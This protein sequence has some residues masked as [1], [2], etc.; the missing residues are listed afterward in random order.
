MKGGKAV[1][2]LTS[3]VLISGV[4]SGALSGCNKSGEVPEL[5]KPITI[6]ESYVSVKYGDVGKTVNTV[7]TVVP[8]YRSVYPHSVVAVEKLY[9]KVGDEVKEGDVLATGVSMAD[10]N[11]MDLLNSEINYL[12]SDIG[13]E[14]RIGSIES[15]IFDL[16]MKFNSLT[17]QGDQND[18]LKTA[19]R[20]SQLNTDYSVTGMRKRVKSLEKQ[21]KELREDIDK[22]EIKAPVSG[23]IVYARNIANATDY[24]TT[25]DNALFIIEDESEKFIE[26]YNVNQSQFSMDDRSVYYL[27]NGEKTKLTPVEYTTEENSR[28]RIKD[29]Y[30]V[31]LYKC[32]V[33]GVEIGDQIPVTIEADTKKTNVLTVDNNAVN[34]EGNDAYVYVKTDSGTEKRFITIGSV[35]DLDSEVK[36]GLTEN[37]KVLVYF[38][39]SAPQSYKEIK[40]DYDDFKA[41]RYSEKLYRAIDRSTAVAADNAMKVKDTASHSGNLSAGTELVVADYSPKQSALL[42]AKNQLERNRR[43]HSNSISGFNKS[44]A[45]LEKATYPAEMSPDAVKIMKQINAL[46]ISQLKLQRQSENASFALSEKEYSETYNK[47][48]KLSKEKEVSIKLE[49]DA[50]VELHVRKDDSVDKGAVIYS[51]TDYTEDSIAICGYDDIVAVPIYK[52]ASLEPK[53]GKDLPVLEGKIVGYGGGSGHCYVTTEDENVYVTTA[54]PAYGSDTQR[55]MVDFGKNCIS[56]SVL[57]DYKGKYTEVDVNGIVSLPIECIFWEEVTNIDNQSGYKPY[58][59]KK[60]DEGIVQSYVELFKSP[61]LTEKIWVIK[62]V[63]PGE[64]ILQPTGAEAQHTNHQEDYFGKKK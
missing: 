54:A 25:S 12:N 48:K 27:H 58:V 32:D 50:K 14:R 24:M 5:V 23:K 15:E 37:D 34:Y 41:Y 19:K 21:K 28:M 10:D 49:E 3:V 31:L 6:P 59:W 44:I 62:G 43:S 61:V 60:T 52:E 51:S 7:G 35:D 56:D 55:I 2:K 22:L 47:L 40:A 16:Q 11:T 13:I 42:E 20:L 18:D 39:Q 64:T 36:D 53:E 63:S 45:E 46:R 4:V 29:L 57:E 1:S 26:I 17:G 30:P 9:A 33:P 8:K 38:S